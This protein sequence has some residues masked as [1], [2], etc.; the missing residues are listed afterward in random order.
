MDDVISIKGQMFNTLVAITE[1][2]QC[3]GLMYQKW[4]PP[5]MAF[6]YRRAAP[7]KF[8]MKNTMTPL[9]IVFCR[10]N[11][12]IG[13]FKGEPLSTKLVGPDEPADFVVELPAGTAANLGLSVGDYVGFTPTKNTAERQRKYGVSF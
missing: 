1:S 13:I 10:G 5:I 6:P 7:R 2:E 9:D 8:W 3:K 12:V 4:P 11:Y